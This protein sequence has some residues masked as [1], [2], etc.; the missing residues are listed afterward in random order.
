MNNCPNNYDAIVIGSGIGS[1]TTA[2][3]LAK[4]RKMRVLVLEQHFNLGGQTH[5]FK[6]KGKFE[7][8]VGLHYSC[9]MGEGNARIIF[10]YITNGK[11]KW[12][13]L[14]EDFEKFI[15]PDFQFNM[16]SSEGAFKNRLFERYPAE[17]NAISRYFRDMKSASLWYTFAHINDTFPGWA[18]WL[19]KSG[20]RRW[21][22]F[23]NITAKEYF[24]L[25]FK[26]PQLKALLASQWG[27]Y[28]LPPGEIA[29]GV[30]GLVVTSSFKGGWYPVGGGKEI[31]KAI[32]PIIEAAGGKVISRRTVDEI[33][34]ENN[35]A[36]GVRVHDTIKPDRLT[37]EYFAP[38]IISGAGAKNTFLKLLPNHFELP[39]RQD[40]EKVGDG[41]S[42][43]CVYIGLKESPEKLGA[44]AANYW[45]FDNYNHGIPRNS[46]E[47][48]K[49]CFLSFPS[50]RNPKAKAHT[51]S[52][53]TW[54]NYEEFAQWQT[55]P[56]KRRGEEYERT[57]Q[58]YA[59]KVIDNIELLF[60]GFSDLIAYVDVSTPLS[61]EHFQGNARGAF[62]GIPANIDRLFKVWTHSKTPVKN[63]Y[64]TGSD[65]MC[66][67]VAGAMVGGVKCAGE[68]MGTFG[69]FRLM[70]MMA[71]AEKRA[72]RKKAIA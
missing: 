24:D 10:D 22:R 20:F 69:F 36:V 17:K 57:K 53:V 49:N 5:E 42:A 31:A 28:G 43:L 58:E 47:F 27:D 8:D 29:F 26:D 54:V 13:K 7:F 4:L 12:H 16:P 51:A 55:R 11:V 65:V 34:I 44:D 6:R 60:P 72:R 35:E 30:H 64:L 33:L 67:G 21:G 9:D 23:A 41:Y 46:S 2:V 61:M 50:L 59:R 71:K 39:F 40:L 52:I 19:V 32:V 56:W 48:P 14:P 18:R 68:F 45:I 66:I 37:E 63:L 3:L 70:M 25:H 38:I 62:Y 15:Y 1:L